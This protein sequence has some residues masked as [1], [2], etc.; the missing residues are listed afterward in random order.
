MKSLKILATAA[1]CVALAGAVQASPVPLQGRDINGNPV[2]ANDPRAMFEYDANL[3]LTWL[4]NWNRNGA[5]DWATAMDWA[6]TLTVGAFGGWALPS[7]SDYG[8]L[9]S[10]VGNLSLFTNV[11]NGLYWSG[12][13]FSPDISAWVF[14]P[15]YGGQSV[16]LEDVLFFAVAVRP[17]DVAAAVPEPQTLALTLLAL[18][19]AVVTRRRRPARAFVG[20]VARLA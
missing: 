18:G 6:A 3:N 20:A 11:Q 13:E 9:F 2:T 16:D 17:G 15:A 5:M 19:A 12:T 8:T 14:Y 4:R 7:I 10:E 1:C